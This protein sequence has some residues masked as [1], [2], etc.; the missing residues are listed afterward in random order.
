M[1]D[2]LSVRPEPEVKRDGLGRPLLRRPDGS[3][4]PYTRVSTLAGTLENRYRLE[5]WQQRLVIQGL[6]V[7]PELL[8]SAAAHINDKN[9]LDSIAEQAQAA[10]KARAK[11]IIGT[12]LHKFTADKD[13]GLTLGPVP[14]D[15]QRWLDEYDR[16]VA[17]L[18]MILIERFTV[19]EEVGVAGTP[20]RIV[21]YPRGSGKYYIAD[22]KTGDIRRAAKIAIQLSCYAHSELCDVITHDRSPF[23]VQVSRTAGI[24]LE[25]NQDTNLPAAL[26][27]VNLAKGWEYVQLAL[28]VRQ[29]QNAQTKLLRRIGT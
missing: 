3:I 29:S 23:P 28:Q 8:L 22:L 15:W 26:Q 27:W 20:D 9:E 16:V 18:K 6:L 21:E 13:R 7:S 12:A 17:P 24:V 19:C 2:V 1:T 4:G 10:A 14:G 5:K 25:V 11:A